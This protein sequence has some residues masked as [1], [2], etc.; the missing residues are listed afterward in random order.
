V[1]N[2]MRPVPA[3]PDAETLAMFADGRIP[4]SELAPLVAHIDE[5][6]DCMTALEAANDVTAASR[7]P[8]RVQWWMAAAAALIVAAIALGVFQPWRTR[9]P[10]DRL[11][12]LVPETERPSE[13][14]L[15]GGF[16]WAAYLGPMRADDADAD[17]R[18]MQLV[19]AAGE[20]VAAADRDRSADAQQAAGIALVV[21]DRPLQAV[22]RLRAAVKVSPKDAAAWSDL[23]AAQY[24]AALRLARPSML[25][26]ALASADRALGIEPRLPE[27]RFNRALILERLG[28]SQEART[29]WQHYLDVDSS[30]PWAN[31]A[32][33]RLSK[34]AAVPAESLFRRDLPR[35]EQAADSGDAKTLDALL[36]GHAQHTRAF[37]EAEMLGR[38]AEASSDRDLRMARSIGDALLRRGGES[39]LHDAVQAIDA[40]APARRAILA[41]AHAAYRRGRIAYSRQ[42]LDVARDALARAA[43]RFEEGGSPMR[44]AARYYAAN[45]RF[46]QNDVAGASRSLEA[47]LRELD[48]HPR[49]IALAAQA[50]W[51]RAL[52]FMVGGDWSGALPLLEESRDAFRRL[53]EHNHHG[54]IESLLADTL[55]SLGR[56]EEAWAA[57]IRAFTLLSADGRGDRLPVSLKAAAQ[58]ELRSGR[59]RPRARCS[60]S[61]GRPDARSPMTS[62]PRMC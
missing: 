29:A 39:L 15:S 58:M 7:A 13:A 20:L 9:S 6:E 37:A 44:F 48:A 34:I 16:A 52:C 61:S 25:P 43:A 54:F 18:R 27:A 31:E 17:P 14:R 1:T 53:G 57:R 12:R 11:V 22:E 41:D 2:E 26:E 51:E 28:L 60:I 49:F 35:I 55:L 56:P 19:G 59:L 45:V 47:L 30:S 23:A 46:D 4:R 40:A 62:P 50:R 42:Q 32:R 8:F 36:A 21:T 24:A 33:R 3:C 38:W 5:C 10:M